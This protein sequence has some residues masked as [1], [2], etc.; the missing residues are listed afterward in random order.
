[1]V[2]EMLLVLNRANNKEVFRVDFT[3]LLQ[4]RQALYSITETG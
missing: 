2:R 1:M 3:V 4:S